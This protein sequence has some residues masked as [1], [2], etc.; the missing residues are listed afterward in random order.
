MPADNSI[1]IVFQDSDVLLTRGKLLLVDGLLN[2]VYI[3]TVNGRLRMFYNVAQVFQ[4][5]GE[6]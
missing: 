3:Q 4:G 5:R 1:R 2:V 6:L